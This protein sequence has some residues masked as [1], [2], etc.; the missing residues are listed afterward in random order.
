MVDK[1]RRDRPSLIEK[2]DDRVR[3]A[4]EITKRCQDWVRTSR[5]SLVEKYI[6]GNI[7][8]VLLKVFQDTIPTIGDYG[9]VFEAGPNRNHVDA[10]VPSHAIENNTCRSWADLNK[11]PVLSL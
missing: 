1:S 2:T 7:D 6:E 10:L 4:R 5:K 8:V 9:L 3:K 11:P